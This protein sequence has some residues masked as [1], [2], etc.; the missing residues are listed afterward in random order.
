MY[1]YGVISATLSASAV[2]SGSSSAMLSNSDGRLE[3]EIEG[4]LEDNNGLLVDPPLPFECC[5][6]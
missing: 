2:L 3:S 1:V 5:E 4:L 6:E